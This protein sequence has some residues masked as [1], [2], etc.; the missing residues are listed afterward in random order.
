MVWLQVLSSRC[1]N[2][3]C[4]RQPL[5]GPLVPPSMLLNSL[6]TRAHV[7][8][9]GLGEEGVP[10]QLGRQYP[11]M[12]AWKC[13]R[14]PLSTGTVNTAATLVTL[15]FRAPT[16]TLTWHPLTLKPPG[17]TD[18]APRSSR[19]T[20]KLCARCPLVCSWVASWLPGYKDTGS[21]YCPSS[22]SGCRAS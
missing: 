4:N 20:K 9:V 13:R 8:Q 11:L 14:H 21:S 2:R 6:V 18:T 12:G 1:A 5:H 17:L 10:Q 22:S 15:R 3:A 19:C 16:A 7:A